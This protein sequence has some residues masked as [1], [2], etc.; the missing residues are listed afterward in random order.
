MKIQPL[1]KTKKT[2]FL[3]LA[4][5]LFLLIILSVSLIAAE[6]SRS[7]E[8]DK[9]GI[10]AFVNGF[11]YTQ[12]PTAFNGQGMVNNDWTT[13]NKVCEL[14]GYKTALSKGCLEHG[15]YG[16]CT[17]TSTSD[18]YMGVWNPSSNDFNIVSAVGKTW[19]ASLTCVDPFDC[20]TDDDCDDDDSYTEDKC[21]N[22]GTKESRCEN[23]PIDCKSNSDCGSNGLLGDLYCN[24]NN[25]FDNFITY[26]CENPGTSQ[27]TCSY[28]L[29]SQMVEDCG[30]D[31]CGDYGTNYCKGDDVYDSRMC[32][33]N[34]CSSGACVSSVYLDERLVQV[35]DDGCSN[36]ACINIVHPKC[37]D[38]VDN[39]NDGLIDM[40]DLGCDS[41]LDDDEKDCYVNFDCGVDECAGEENYC[42]YNDVYQDYN[43]F[44]CN[45]AGLN[46]AFCSVD[47]S[48][49]KIMECGND[50]YG[51]WEANYCYDD[52]V[53][54][55]RTN[56]ERGCS[57][58][59]CFANTFGEIAKV[60]E[61]D[62]G[63]SNGDCIDSTC[64]DK[65]LDGY[66]TCNPG[67]PGDDG[68][69]KDCNDNNSN[70]NPGELE[71]CNGIDDNCN[72][73]IDEGDVCVTECSDNIDNDN[74]DLIDELDPGCWED[75]EDSS[76]YNPLLDDESRASSVCCEDEDCGV[77]GYVGENY[78]SEGKVVRDFREYICNNL[79]LGTSECTSLLTPFLIEDCGEDYCNDYDDDFC[80]NGDVYH[81]RTCYNFG[82]SSE[83]CT[84]DS[85]E[86]SE[87]VEDCDFGC[88]NGECKEEE[89]DDEDCTVAGECGNEE[90]QNDFG[91]DNIYP[92][93]DSDRETLEN[94]ETISLNGNNVDD[95]EVQQLGVSNSLN[96]DSSFF[97]VWSFILI[98]LIVV[99]LIF[100][101]IAVLFR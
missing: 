49:F 28:G 21:I 5:A 101:V 44:T 88:S 70:V 10:R 84:S 78:C 82:C 52:D 98:L 48:P 41:P 60:A 18:N 75:L 90:F 68:R 57:N 83:G 7:W 100:I 53:Y 64:E 91:N 74:D 73:L 22:P 77:D 13:A 58:K 35:C 51:S 27:S 1:K 33:V 95:N 99:V 96:D 92:D 24:L 63:C 55:S 38:G 15:T 8:G 89:E 97:G 66:D 62:Y 85:F 9:E 11:G 59:E 17:F 32:G 65:D 67:E 31:S 50:Y 40:N 93:D 71:V 20:F 42:R 76:T 54:H 37:S 86:N 80:R 30:G 47:V 81:K 12:I 61:C 69:E 6:E 14:A 34:G 56:T 26:I 16:R 45:N 36:G 94:F 19:L 39:D 29:N 72:G 2:N 25:V 3:G 46:S 4:I 79:G 43:F 23:D 87:K